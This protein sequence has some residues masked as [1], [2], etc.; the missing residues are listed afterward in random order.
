MQ[1]IHHSYIFLAA[2][3][4][5]NAYCS[6]TFNE[7]LDDSDHTWRV[8]QV[9]VVCPADHTLRVILKIWRKCKWSQVCDHRTICSWRVWG[10]AGRIM[11][12]FSSQVPVRAE[13]YKIKNHVYKSCFSLSYTWFL[14]YYPLITSVIV[15]K[16][17][18][19]WSYGYHII[20]LPFKHRHF[21]RTII[22]FSHSQQFMKFRVPGSQNIEDPS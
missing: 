12:V 3:T 7:R 19:T 4:N 20:T 10:P 2:L 15:N 11:S 13:T 6:H 1:V 9:Y 18:Q 14:L 8:I 17:C 22:T 5:H 21:C 16:W